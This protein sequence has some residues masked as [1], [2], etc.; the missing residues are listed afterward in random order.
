MHHM[1]ADMTPGEKVRWKLHKNPMSYIK[2]ILE[3]T[4]HETTAVR[5]LTPIS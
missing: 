1:D 3:A 2:Q 5:Q 4:T